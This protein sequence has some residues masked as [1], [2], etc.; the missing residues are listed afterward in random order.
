[1]G[2]CQTIIS[3][4]DDH[5]LTFW[6]LLAE[7][8]CLTPAPAQSKSFFDVLEKNAENTQKG[9][10]KGHLEDFYD[11][12]LAQASLWLAWALK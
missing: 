9:G 4:G 11:L 6:F 1:M 8:S 3:S 5:L 2:N 10:K 12:W 7:L